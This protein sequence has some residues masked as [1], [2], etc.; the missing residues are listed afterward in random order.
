MLSQRK[1]MATSP[2]L[3]ELFENPKTT[4]GALTGG[5]VVAD[6]LL[7]NPYSNCGWGMT[8]FTFIFSILLVNGFVSLAVV[9][10]FDIFDQLIGLFVKLIGMIGSAITT[11][12]I[13]K[14]TFRTT[15]RK[16]INNARKAHREKIEVRK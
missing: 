9:D 15:K 5:A 8:I 16:K 1:N 3:N 12:A 7:I 4:V 2:I 10:W 6:K 13:Y 11:Y 14:K